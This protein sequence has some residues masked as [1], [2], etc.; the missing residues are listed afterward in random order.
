MINDNTDMV[1]DSSYST[2]AALLP[3]LQFWEKRLPASWVQTNMWCGI[4]QYTL[5]IEL[6]VVTGHLNM[7][8]WHRHHK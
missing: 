4:L 5:H 2:H 6:S 8:I 1:A 7:T 3:L